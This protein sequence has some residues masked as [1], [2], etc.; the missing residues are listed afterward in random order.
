LGDGPIQSLDELA[1]RAAKPL[2]VVQGQRCRTAETSG[3]ARLRRASSEA[4]RRP[5][6]TATTS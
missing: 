2:A 5:R 3:E 1:Q 6:T 4:R